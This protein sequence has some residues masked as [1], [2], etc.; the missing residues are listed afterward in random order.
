MPRDPDF[1]PH[2]VIPAALLPFH[3][4]L[5]IDEPSFRAH[6]RDVASVQGLSAITVNAHSTEVASCTLDEQRRVM[7]IAGEEVGGKLPVIHGVWADGSLEA[8]RIARQ[9][10]AGAASALLVFPPAPFTLGQSAEMALAHFKTIADASDLPIIVF[11]YPLSTGQG[12]P[13]ATLERLFE[14]VPTIRAIKDWTPQVPQHESQI[15]ALQGRKRP[16]NVLSTNSAWLLSS[17]VL[18]CNGLLSGSGSVIADL[19]AKLFRAVKANDLA[20]AR[21]L[22]DRISP[23]ARVFY[24]DPFVDMHNRMKEALVL[25][26]KLPRAVVRP[27]LVKIG[28][29][30]IARIRD[31]LIEAGLLDQNAALGRN[32]A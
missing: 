23:T 9:A 17:L 7:E 28:E 15:R 29:A 11:Q 4:D 22:N 3:T 24:A 6:L 18:G 1:V 2:G 10:Q 32:A 14:E 27:P 21:R 26:G 16:I 13:M 12:Y 25:L 31:A 30:E 19:Q 5:A 8:A 20:E